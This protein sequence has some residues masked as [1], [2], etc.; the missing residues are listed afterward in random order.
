[1]K[2]LVLG[3]TGWVG[4]HIVRY[5]HDAGHEV[6]AGSRGKK[7]DFAGEMPDGIE[8]V[9]VDKSGETEMAELLENRFEIIIDTVPTEKSIDFVHKYAKGLRRYIHCSSTGGYAPLKV[10]P[11]DETHPYG[12]AFG[13]GW[14]NKQ[15]VDEKVM[16]L[17]AEKG[18]PATVIRPCYITGQG[19]VPID[20]LGGRRRDFIQD[21]IHGA[22]IELPNDGRSLLQPIEV[23]ELA[24]SFLLCAGTDV[25]I[26]QT[27]NICLEKSVTLTRYIE[28][29]AAALEK[30]V[31]IVYLPLVELLEKYKGKINETGLRFLA[32]HMCFDISKARNQIGYEPR[33]STEQAIENT[34]RW[35][36]AI[37]AK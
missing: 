26:G 29:T 37:Q 5:Y 21:I 36:A 31:S 28:I 33:F 4:H 27:Y 8:S 9:T 19:M 10:V 35:A 17:F 23:T 18:F 25:S 14:K 34:A 12:A 20:N 6:V 2:T 3:G 16:R 32:E 30:R 11:A 7:K 22:E 15:I 1:M 24:R 13:S